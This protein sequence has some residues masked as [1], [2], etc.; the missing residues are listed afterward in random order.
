MNCPQISREAIEK[1]IDLLNKETGHQF[2][3]ENLQGELEREPDFITPSGD[4][5]ILTYSATSYRI[6]I[7]LHETIYGPSISYKK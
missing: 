5:Q 2:V 1:V 3:L 6:N 7:T 4:R